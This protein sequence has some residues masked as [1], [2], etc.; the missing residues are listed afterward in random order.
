MQL[1]DRVSDGDILN[2]VEPAARDWCGPS[3]QED[4]TPL[5]APRLAAAEH[6]SFE[7]AGTIEG[8]GLFARPSHP[9]RG[10]QH[11]GRHRWSLSRARHAERSP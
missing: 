11:P 10:F 2:I 9:N 1:R 6:R 5:P 3:V 4:P 8:P 7:A